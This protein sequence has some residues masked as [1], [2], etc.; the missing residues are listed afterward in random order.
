VRLGHISFFGLGFVNLLFAFSIRATPVLAPFGQ[1][2]ALGLLVGALTMPLACF[3]TAWQPP[4]RQLF[5]IPVLGV[6]AGIVSLLVG[7]GLA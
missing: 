7:W 3:L 2:G 5:P 4:F 6:L 1:L